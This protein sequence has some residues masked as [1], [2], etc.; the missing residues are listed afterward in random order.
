MDHIKLMDVQSD[1]PDL[2]ILTERLDKY[3][4]ELY[5]PEE[6]FQVDYEDPSKDKIEIVI[7]YL[8]GKPVGCGAI[9]EIDD[10]AVELKRF[11]VLEDYR[12][13]GIAGLILKTMESKARSKNYKVMRLETGDQQ[14][15]A[16][17]F[18]SKYEFYEIDRFGE[19]ADCPSSVCME[20]TL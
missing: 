17:G 12:N 9:K 5:P 20:K 2:S 4:Y 18:Y 10:R 11:F 19:Y 13:Q 14:V 1:H 8:Q 16:I 6:V 3:L 15:E 7:A